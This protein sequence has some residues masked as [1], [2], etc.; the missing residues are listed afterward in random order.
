MGPL[1]E[2]VERLENLDLRLSEILERTSLK[3]QL[4]QEVVGL[5]HS[6]IGAVFHHFL[7]NVGSIFMQ[8]DVWRNFILCMVIER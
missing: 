5:P 8:V 4:L 3:L 2:H 6:T 7:E 1:S